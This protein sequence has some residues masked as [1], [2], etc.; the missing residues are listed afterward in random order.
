[1]AAEENPTLHSRR[2]LNL[3]FNIPTSR[4]H[5][6]WDALAGGSFVTTKCKSCGKV[7]FPPQADC[8]E[9][10]S[11]EHEWVDLGAEAELLTFTLVQ[12]TPTSFVDHDPYVV[13]IGR[14]KQ[15]LNVL[16]WLEGMDHEKLKPGRKLRIEFRRDPGAGPY[17]VFVPAD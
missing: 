9:C 15:G 16:A 6:F 7:T 17:Y 4:T 13:A 1:M 14:L 11:G 3:R 5:E 12:I 2:G 8:P 10:M